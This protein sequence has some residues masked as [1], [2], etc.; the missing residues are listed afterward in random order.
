VQESGYS[1]LPGDITLTNGTKA[2]LQIDPK[3]A[4]IGAFGAAGDGAA[5][6]TAAFIAGVASNRTLYLEDNKT[7]LVDALLFDSINNFK[8]IGAENSIIKLADAQTNN[9][10]YFSNSTDIKIDGVEIDGNRTN[11]TGF[12]GLDDN[13]GIWFEDC[14]ATYVDNCIIRSTIGGGIRGRNCNRWHV[15]DNYITDVGSWPISCYLPGDAV[16]DKEYIMVSGNYVDWEDQSYMVGQGDPAKG[17][18]SDTPPRPVCFAGGVSNDS[19]LPKTKDIYILNN[20]FKQKNTGGDGGFIAHIAGKNWGD[21]LISGNK[22]YGGGMGISGGKN[23]I[24]SIITD[25]TI[26]VPASSTMTDVAYGIEGGA[27]VVNTQMSG[28]MIDGGGHYTTGIQQQDSSGNVVIEGGT[29]EGCLDYAVTHSNT[30]G[31]GNTNLTLRPGYWKGGSSGAGVIRIDGVEG[32]TVTGGVLDGA[33]VAVG[34]IEYIL[35]ANVSAVS[36]VTFINPEGSS[37]VRLRQQSGVV[38]NIS[39]SGCS[40]PA[41]DASDRYLRDQTGGSASLGTGLKYTGCTNGYDILDLANNIISATDAGT[42][43]GNLVAGVGS[44]YYRTNGGAGTTFYVKETLTTS[45]GWVGK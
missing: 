3:G 6:D 17:W 8:L 29:I 43:E 33:G 27:Q 18:D 22:L 38:A 11:Q 36:G 10:I 25:N 35:G 41:L 21:R 20:T 40:V 30:G 1:L 26:V 45:S 19:D 44:R 39:I 31:T 13:F 4:S 14:G 32:S 2:Q 5:D 42:P 12:Y 9:V 34:A 24:N 28:N 15:R 23:C 37:F 16:A 7:Y